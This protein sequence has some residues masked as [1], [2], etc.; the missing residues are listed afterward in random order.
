MSYSFSN[1]MFR[2]KE[3]GL[4]TRAYFSELLYREWNRMIREQSPLSLFLINPN[5]D[6]QD[7]VGRKQFIA[8][9]KL[10]E[11]NV[12]RSTDLIARFKGYSITVAVFG[13]DDHGTNTIL[14]RLLTAIKQV[15]EKQKIHCKHSFIAATNLMPS[16]GTDI[17]QVIAQLE[18]CSRKNSGRNYKFKPYELIV[19]PYQASLSESKQA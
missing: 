1:T 4:H 7:A 6:V 8:F 3:T 12:M 9:A 19:Q 17:N 10:V 5:I 13:Q 14:T 11:S 15:N 18:T 16:R 2:D